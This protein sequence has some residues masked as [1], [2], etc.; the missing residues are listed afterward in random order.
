MN[1]FIAGDSTAACKLPEKR[2][3]AGWGEFLTKHFNE[4]V[5]V[6]NFAKNGRSTK[7][8][9][10]EGTLDIIDSELAPGDYLLIQ[11]GHNDEKL[12]DP[13]R[14]TTPFGS[15]QHN[16]KKFIAVA[17]KNSAT[18]ILL[19]SMTRRQFNDDGTM[20]ADTVGNYPAAVRALGAE[21]GVTVLDGY[22]ASQ[23]FY[24]AVGDDE[25]RHY[26]LQLAKS[27]HPNY[28]DGVCDNTHANYRG[29]KAGAKLIATE[30]KKSSSSLKNYLIAG[31][32]N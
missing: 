19:T 31:G 9:I 18:P 25:S 6:R 10:A 8:F 32:K 4:D 1:I 29:A 12:S 16:L 24:K 30:I 5:D 22:A 21:L 23:A 15:Y 11:F 17:E 2:P 13:E 20:V 3:E 7:S 27:A 26:F 28:P 14:G